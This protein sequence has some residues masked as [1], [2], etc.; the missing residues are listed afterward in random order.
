MPSWGNRAMNGREDLNLIISECY[1]VIISLTANQRAQIERIN[2][3]PIRAIHTRL[4][5]IESFVV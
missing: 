4:I 2:A 1:S 5:T 3:E